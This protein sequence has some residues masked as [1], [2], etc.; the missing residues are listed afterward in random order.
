MLLRPYQRV[1]DT[2]EPYLIARPPV[3]SGLDEQPL[4]LDI[5]DANVFDP[6]RVAGSTFIQLVKHVDQLAYGPVGLSMPAWVFYDCAVMPGAVFGFA[7]RAHQLES[8]SRRALAVP[9]DYRGLVPVSIFICIP[10]VARTAALVYTLCS[11][12]Q[13]A[14]GTAPEGLWRLTL[15]AGTQAFRLT[16]ML[17]TCQWRSPQLGL[18]AGLGPLRLETAWTPAHDNPATC[19]FRVTTDA[20][21]RE[22][23]LRGDLLGPEGIHR[24]IDADDTRAMRALQD[25]IEAGARVAVV[26]PAEIRGSDTRVPLQ[27]S[28]AS[29]EFATEPGVGFTRR[30]QG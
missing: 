17:A 5:P 29:G 21:A 16:E 10:T 12:N 23:L 3:R 20:L 22:R 30:F 24:Y 13:I 7:R 14:P 26:G 6:Q 2:C 11:V 9:D 15:A 19:T 8:W 27:V 25:D 1:L 18:Y 28:A 4:G